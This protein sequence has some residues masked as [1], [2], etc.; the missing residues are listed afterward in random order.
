MNRRAFTLVEL[1]AV[2]V[3]LAILAGVAVP[4]Y[5]DYRQRA[6]TSAIAGEV[7]AVQRAGWTHFANLGERVT[8]QVELSADAGFLGL[9]DGVSFAMERAD[10]H[11]YGLFNP[12]LAP[13]SGGSG[14]TLFMLGVSRPLGSG[15]TLDPVMVGVQ[16][17]FYGNGGTVGLEFDE[18]A[19]GYE[20]WISS[21]FVD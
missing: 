17:A 16:Q 7:R 10:G 3:V 20:K 11:G 15:Q 2:I 6:L 8:Q 21:V 5:F 9:L 19:D 14:R 4:R 13:Q 12:R 1:I 18:E